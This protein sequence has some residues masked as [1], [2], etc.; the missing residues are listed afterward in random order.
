MRRRK[1]GGL[2]KYVRHAVGTVF[3]VLTTFV[4]HH[5]S[6]NV[7]LAVGQNFKQV[8]H[9]VGFEPEEQFQVVGRN[10][11]PVVGAVRGSGAV[12]V[13]SDFHE[14]LEETAVVVLGTLEHNVLE[15]V[16]K[17]G[18]ALVFIL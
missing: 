18:L 16:G 4:L 3:V 15:E 9:P 14:G 12:Q 5:I 6:L 1:H 11:H 17:A 2:E 13:C 7:E 8:A 10:V